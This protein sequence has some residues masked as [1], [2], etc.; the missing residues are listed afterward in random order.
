MAAK[1]SDLLL[2]DPEGQVK[3]LYIGVE[4]G[5]LDTVIEKDCGALTPQ[6]E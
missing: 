6:P 1:K 3:S 5:F 4:K 2:K